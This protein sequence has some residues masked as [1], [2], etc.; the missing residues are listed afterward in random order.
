MR[1]CPQA[2]HFINSTPDLNFFK[3]VRTYDIVNGLKPCVAVAR[4][5]ET[6]FSC[7]DAAI[8]STRV[9]LAYALPCPTCKALPFLTMCDLSPDAVLSQILMFDAVKIVMTREER[10]V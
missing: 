10:L 6:L 3:N 5:F 1:F 2:K 7:C 8:S 4:V 9:V